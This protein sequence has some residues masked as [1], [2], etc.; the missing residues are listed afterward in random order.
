MTDLP[1]QLYKLGQPVWVAPGYKYFGDWRGQKLI[2]VGAQIV[3]GAV[4]Y[5]TADVDDDGKLSVGTTDG[6]KEQDL[7]VF[8]TRIC[9]LM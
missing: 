6:W 8:D 9:G 2:V 5:T 1:M 4:E 3:A 7:T